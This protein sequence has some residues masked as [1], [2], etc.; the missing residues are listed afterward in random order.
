MVQ[1]AV[2]YGMREGTNKLHAMAFSSTATSSL[3]RMLFP[4]YKVRANR[5]RGN[6]QTEWA[7]LSAVPVLLSSTTAQQ[8]LLPLQLRC[9][10]WKQVRRPTL[11]SNNGRGWRRLHQIRQLQ[12]RTDSD[13]DPQ[14]GQ[15]FMDAAD[16][17]QRH[18]SQPHRPAVETLYSNSAPT[19]A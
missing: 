16:S 15:Q 14:T 5:S 19:P 17:A 3:T 1:G 13:Y 4:V 10:S 8:D 2:D 7:P 18:L 9:Y 11:S 12:R 6:I